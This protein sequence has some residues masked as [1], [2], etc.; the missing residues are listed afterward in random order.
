[1]S[2]GNSILKLE[3]FRIEFIEELF[4]ASNILLTIEYINQVIRYLNWC[5]IWKHKFFASSQ[6]TYFYSFS[7]Q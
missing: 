6:A 1:M 4:I 3:S 2:F 7:E 5:G